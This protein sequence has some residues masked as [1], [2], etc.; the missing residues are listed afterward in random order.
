MCNQF[1]Q[2]DGKITDKVIADTNGTNVVANQRK[3]EIFNLF[4]EV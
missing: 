4:T 1:M 2:S 3:R